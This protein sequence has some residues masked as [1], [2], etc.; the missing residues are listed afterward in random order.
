MIEMLRPKILCKDIT[1]E[2]RFWVD[3]TGDV[4]PLHSTY[5][6]VP[7]HRGLIDPLM[8]F[9]NS[10]DARKW[11]H[12]NCQRAANGF[13][14]MQSAILKKLPIPDELGQALTDEG[15]DAI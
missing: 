5:Y 15:A 7:Q 9:L 6:I 10:A 12:A 11:L 2:P 3:E 14:R 4:V 13:L 8:R 1:G